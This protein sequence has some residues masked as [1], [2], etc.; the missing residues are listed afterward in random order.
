MTD[1]TIFAAALEKTDPTERAAFVVAACAT[2]A[3]LQRRVERLLAAHDAAS[4]FLERPLAS[5]PEPDHAHTGAYRAPGAEPG[6]GPTYTHGDRAE[7][8][9]TDDALAFLTPSVR[10]DSLGRIGHYE[11]LQVL[12]KGGFGV[13]FRAFDNVLQR[14]VAVKVMAPSMAATSPARKRFLR[15]ARSSAAVR[16]ENVVQVHAVE[17]QPLPHLVMEFVPGET[18]Q[19][20]LDRT[21]PLEL[22]EILR[23][24]RQLAA[25]LAAAHEKGLIHRDI[26]PS[27]ILIDAGPH[28]NVKLTD[29]GLARAADD[30]SLTRSG[31]VAGTPMYMAPEQAK[32]ETL[33]HR[34]DLFSLGSV[35]YVMCTGRPPFRASNTLAVL[36]RV[37]EDTPRPIREVIPEVPEW[38]C[39]VVEKLHEKEPHDRIQT[40][41]EVADLLADC[42]TQL[43]AH[44]V[45]TDY[46]R[47]PGGKPRR[48]KRWKWVAAAL[49][50]ILLVPLVMFGVALL[51][52]NS[53]RSNPTDTGKTDPADTGKIEIK[54]LPPSPP[55]AEHDTTVATILTSDE[56]EWTELINL[57][58]KINSASADGS[59]WVSA[60]GLTL[61]FSS[62][63]P[64]G[65]GAYDLWQ[66]TRSSVEEDWSAPVNVGAP[67]N[68][69][70]FEWGAM[71]SADGRTLVF[72]SARP[73]G[74]G[75]TDIWIATRTSRDA[76]WGNPVN[77]G[78]VINSTAQ[79]TAP[80]LSDDGRQLSFVSNRG[81][82]FHCWISKRPSVNDPWSK[83]EQLFDHQGSRFQA[84][85]SGK[86][87]LLS[88]SDTAI[89]FAAWNEADKRWGNIELLP[90]AINDGNRNARMF[91]HA[92][93]HTLYFESNRPG[94]QGGADLWMSRRVKKAPPKPDTGVADQFTLVSR[95]ES[96][97]RSPVVCLGVSADGR[98]ALSVA[99]FPTPNNFV[100]W[101]LNATGGKPV[102]RETLKVNSFAAAVTPAGDCAVVSSTG[103]IAF[104][105]L[106]AM[107][108][109]ASS[110]EHSAM[111]W[112]LAISADGKRAITGAHDDDFICIWELPLGKLIKKIPLD[113]K[114]VLGIAIT[115]D[116]KQALLG[117]YGGRCELWDLDKG[118][119]V[120]RIRGGQAGA[121]GA[122]NI[123]LSKDGSKLLVAI[124]IDGDY[125]I[126][127]WD[128]GTGKQLQEFKGHSHYVGGL[129]FLPDGE[130]FLSGAQDGTLRVWSLNKGK[131]VARFTDAELIVNS[132]ELLPDGRHFL[133]AGGMKQAASGKDTIYDAGDYDLR[134]WRLPQSVWPTPPPAV[135]PFDAAKAK[136]HQEA[137]AK[138]LG[139]PVEFENS[140]GM[141]LR[142]IPPGEFIMG[143]TDE[144]MKVILENSTDWGKQVARVENPPR[145][146][147]IT[148]SFFMGT[149]EVTVGQFRQFVKETGY[150]TDAESS[151]KGGSMLEDKPTMGSY[152]KMQRPEYTWQNPLFAA[153]DD[154]PVVLI[155]TA[156]GEAF[157][158]WLSKKE[159]RT[160]RLPAE[161]ER[162]YACRAGT[163][164]L[165]YT[166]DDPV[167]LNVAEWTS[168]NGGRKVHSCGGK[169]A[170]PFGLFDMLGNVQELCQRLSS[171]EAVLRG[172][173]I[174]ESPWLSRS[175]TRLA[176]IDGVPSAS[177]GFRVAIVGDLKAKTQPPAR[178]VA[179][180]PRPLP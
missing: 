148:D 87:V 146:S 63:R 126:Q 102:H 164:T 69:K 162:E 155:T 86:T 141:K 119:M 94:G 134:L 8:D 3:E 144:Q 28:R 71:M 108:L 116:G 39:R 125:P 47:I 177:R 96:V 74:Q 137:W 147:R 127:L 7:D 142:L 93:T 70:T 55:V 110:N 29:F 48:P 150:K 79:D 173:H 120:R 166:G 81:G 171:G 91:Y 172:G 61:L 32:G 121:G 12:G 159:G 133:T 140:I 25:G 123:A 115:P 36:K 117:L 41:R 156:D 1:E 124:P 49:G 53:Q 180:A 175:A 19:Q 80:I 118:E 152:K 40:S 153:E 178:E 60:D 37:V 14:V 73:V 122:R 15:E 33:D 145:R 112:G 170:N 62:N 84:L 4:G 176:K 51:A 43:K 97:H 89:G 38:L 64:G 138:H 106:N 109:K 22:P 68:S 98:R 10:P 151:G 139:V 143:S 157:C 52:Y 59:P 165:W 57:G 92:L 67:I 72:S 160:Y 78:A 129:R 99:A 16:H 75:N 85:D 77:L 26:K 101:E 18:L 54:K 30:A 88:S 149:M 5:L 103:S 45:L 31:V 130:H 44:G 11:V 167:Q 154:H 104:W 114:S 13:V 179:P 105:D 90:A 17:E 76:P 50:M 58:P 66:C 83:P 128:V 107:K 42:E 6:D 20:Q 65:L 95:F 136:E 27:N 163:T 113:F 9:D 23:I 161:I 169:T 21:G 35:L 111:P 82:L 24:G 131:E 168:M 135:A 158:R 132:L 2:D 174:Q 34:A 46:S 56:Y 100:V